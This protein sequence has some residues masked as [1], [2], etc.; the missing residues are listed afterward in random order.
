MNS[1]RPE[2]HYKDEDI[3]IMEYSKKGLSIED[4]A[5]IQKRTDYAIKVR[6][7]KK[8]KNQVNIMV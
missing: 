1:Q 3:L 5:K 7:I 4:I 2:R 8:L 6:L